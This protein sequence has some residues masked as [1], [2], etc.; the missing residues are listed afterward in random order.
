MQIVATDQLPEPRPDDIPDLPRALEEARKNRPELEQADLNSRNQDITVQ[1]VR[2]QLLDDLTI[3]AGRVF[4][5]YDLEDKD[6]MR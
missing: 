6:M 2:N 3:R 1:A 4:H 5:E